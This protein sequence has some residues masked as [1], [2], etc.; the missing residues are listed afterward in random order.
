MSLMRTSSFSGVY[1]FY[2]DMIVVAKC[3]ADWRDCTRQQLNKC[4]TFNWENHNR[5]RASIDI[6]KLTGREKL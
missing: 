5:A 1:C 4:N 2:I 6:R 3:I